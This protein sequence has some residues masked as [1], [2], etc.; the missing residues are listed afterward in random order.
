MPL[1]TKQICTYKYIG[2]TIDEK[3]NWSDH[4]KNI[5]A[6]SNKR[7]Y[8][9]FFYKSVFES[10]LRFCITCWGGNSSKE[11]RMKVDRKLR[12]TIPNLYLDDLFCRKS[13]DKI[14]S[15]SKDEKYPL[16][17]FLNDSKSNRIDGHSHIMIK[18]TRAT[19]KIFFD[20]CHLIFK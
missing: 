7:I 4:I 20:I 14:L 9:A 16:S 6:Q 18:K 3:V 19:L 15:T 1:K 2:V 8:F 13:L 11:E 10:I 5:K 12:V 17:C